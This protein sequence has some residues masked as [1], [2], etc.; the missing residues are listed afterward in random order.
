M[1]GPIGVVLACRQVI[2]ALE[3]ASPAA[4]EI[5]TPYT[6]FQVLPTAHWRSTLRHLWSAPIFSAAI[7]LIQFFLLFAGLQAAV[8][9]YEVGEAID[10]CRDL[11]SCLPLPSWA[12]SV[13]LQWDGRGLL[14]FRKMLLFLT[15]M[16]TAAVMQIGWVAVAV[17][18]SQGKSRH[19]GLA[20]ALIRGASELP[21]AGWLG[22]LPMRL[23]AMLCRLNSTPLSRIDW[24]WR[25][26]ILG[27]ICHFTLLSLYAIGILSSRL[28]SAAGDVIN[29]HHKEMLDS[30]G[31]YNLIFAA[32]LISVTLL[33][34]VPAYF[35][36]F[37]AGEVSLRA[38]AVAAAFLAVPMLLGRI[39]L[40]SHFSRTISGQLS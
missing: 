4:S 6:M 24:R 14:T 36:L 39:L 31:T 23:V 20:Y 40:I 22:L 12:S 25:I 28:P 7:L 19:F 27:R 10:R 33:L 35:H 1:F 21:R 32:N 38:T 18:S 13:L 16:I 2:A 11:G 5:D 15:L 3:N 9:V 29:V 26:M 8:E 34:V 17:W 30:F 37:L